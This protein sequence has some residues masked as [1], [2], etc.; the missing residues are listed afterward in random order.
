MVVLDEDSRGKIQTV[1]SASAAENSVLLESAK[2]G[3][4]FARVKDACF[5]ALDGIDVLA[6]KSRDAT[7]MLQ[8]VQ[9]DTFAAEQHSGVVANH[10]K[11]LSFMHA[12]PDK[13]LGVAEAFVA[14]VRGG[15]GIE[16]GEDFMEAGVCS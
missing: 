12:D 8:E 9:D 16:G 6:R 13:D 14:S 4:G 7:E 11:D 3:Y 15:W 5:R 2:A 1:I 10:G